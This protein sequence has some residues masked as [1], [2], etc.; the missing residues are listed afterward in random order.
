MFVGSAVLCAVVGVLA[1]KRRRA[2]DLAPGECEQQARAFDV[3]TGVGIDIS[4][5]RSGLPGG[6]SHQRRLAR[7]RASRGCNRA[8]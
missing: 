5:V 6:N 8:N 7:R 3:L 1:L 4:L 2:Y